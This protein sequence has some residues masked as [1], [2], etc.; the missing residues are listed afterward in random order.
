MPSFRIIVETIGTVPVHSVSTKYGTPF[1]KLELTDA[2]V[3]CS[4]FKGAILGA[5]GAGRSKHEKVIQDRINAKNIAKV[6]RAFT[7]NFCENFFMILTKYS[8]GKRINLGMTDSWEVY[9]LF[10]AGM[11]S[12]IRNGSIFVSKVIEALGIRPS[13]V[14]DQYTLQAN[15]KAKSNA[16]GKRTDQSK[17]RRQLTQVKKTIRVNRE[18]AKKECHKTERM[19][20]KDDIRPRVQKKRAPSKCGNCSEVG[21]TARQCP[22][23]SREKQKKDIGIPIAYLE[24]LLDM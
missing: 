18:T 22:E 24:G 6:A 20:P 7:S 12:N 11:C 23:P 3:K 10:C 1:T 16:L 17:K 21:H 15:K 19:K 14:R 2:Y 4:R 9:Q 8:Q 5:K 13:S